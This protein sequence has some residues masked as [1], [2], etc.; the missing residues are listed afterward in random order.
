MP[1][2]PIPSQIIKVDW[3]RLIRDEAPLAE[4]QGSLTENQLQLAYRRK[5]FKLFVPEEYGGLEASL[6]EAIA[7]EEAL[8]WADGSFGWTITLCGGAGW[9]AGFFDSDLAREVFLYPEACLGGSGA[10]TGTA[11]ITE[12]GYRVSGK[13]K[14]A[15]GSA[16]LTHFTANCVITKNNEPVLHENGKD[17]ILP[18]VFRRDEVK[19]IS[20]WNVMGLIATS[21]NA[22]EVTDLAIAAKRVFKIAAEAAKINLPVYRYPFLQFAETTLAATFSG[23]ALHF[24]DCAESV[25]EKRIENKK[26]SEH[27]KQVLIEALTEAKAKVARV[28]FDFYD[29]INRS[30]EIQESGKPENLGILEEVN[31]MSRKLSSTARGVVAELFP[32]GGLVAADPK[33]EINRV[34]RDFHTASQHPLLNFS[35]L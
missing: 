18:F 23:M 1:A 17:L 35:H 19:V 27:Q 28:R 14:Y 33:T 13:W 31:F 11:E 10:A 9:F 21:S 26:I 22:F 20:D 3:L 29:V 6:P 5:W 16:H 12:S 7:L 2:L 34:W 8:A 15:T 25:F 32:F 24:I 4:K 30:W